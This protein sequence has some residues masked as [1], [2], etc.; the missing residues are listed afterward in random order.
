MGIIQRARP[1]AIDDVANV[2]N[3]G[4]TLKMLIITPFKL[5]IVIA[6]IKEHNIAVV[7][8]KPFP[9]NVI[10]TTFTRQTIA[11]TEISIP[12]LKSTTAIP[13][14]TQT[15]GTLYD[16]KPPML[17]GLK[18]LGL[19]MR[20]IIIKLINNIKEGKDDHVYIFLRIFFISS[21]PVWY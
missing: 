15:S 18:K 1:A 10:K 20:L 8:P 11:P 19:I 21:H 9:I 2:V 12:P 16:K 6:E 14:E 17:R 3:K 13:M 4:V 5:P 7:I